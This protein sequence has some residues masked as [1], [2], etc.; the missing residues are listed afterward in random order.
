MWVHYYDPHYALRPAR[1]L[2]DEVR[3]Q[4]VP[5]RDRGD[6]RAARPAGPRVRAVVRRADGHRRRRRPRRR[7]GRSRRG[8]ARHCSCISRRCTCR[9]CWSGPRVATSV[10]DTPV[11]TRRVFHTVL[12]WAGVDAPNSLL[13]PS[14]DVVLGEAMKPF[15]D[16]GWQPQ[17]MT[18]DGAHKAILTG[19]MEVYD[20]AADPAEAHD[21][22]RRGG[23]C[24]AGPD[25]RSRPIRFR[26]PTPRG[27][28]RLDDEARR[29]SRASATSARRRRRWCGSDAPRPVGH[30]E[31][32]SVARAGVGAVRRGKIRRGVCRCS[33]RI[34]L[35][36]PHNLDAVLQAASAH[37][38]LGHDARALAMFQ[39]AAD[40]APN[41]PD[42]RTYLALHY[43]RGK[44]WARAVPLLERVV[45]DDPNRLPALEALAVMRV[46]QGRVDDAIAL[47]QKI[48]LQ[49]APTAA[50]LVDTGRAAMSAERTPAA[51]EAFE[52]ARALQGAAFA[53]DLELGVLYLADNR[54]D[55][56]A[57]RTRPRAGVQPGLPDGAVQARAGQRAA[58]R[59]RRR[60]PHR[61]RAAEGGRDDA[62]AHRK[63]EAVQAGAGSPSPRAEVDRAPLSGTQRARP[64]APPAP[65]R[66][67]TLAR[68]PG[69]RTL[70]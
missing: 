64:S 25:R 4:A 66:T 34:L 1:A 11:S 6:G 5:R 40:L 48:Y 24:R 15:L 68:D 13:R 28:P 7:A 12:D 16:Y 3:G 50:E 38:A 14:N 61:P 58:A 56:G 39:K 43:A 10:S 18:V 23:D 60:G 67:L 59:A 42:V 22:A 31:D 46:R 69:P 29:S 19:T 65:T 45:A 17:V 20:L 49:R 52:R 44:D 47:R 57:D 51:I 63:G 9:S 35:P 30:A 32:L 33:S 53:H 27:P 21:L 62:R 2:P 26:R 8:A 37:S 36:I 41:S 70:N 54:F 55:R